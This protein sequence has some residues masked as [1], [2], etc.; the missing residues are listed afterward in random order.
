MRI[1]LPTFAI[2][3]A[4]FFLAVASAQPLTCTPESLDVVCAERGAVR[5]VTEGRTFA[6]KGIPY[7]Q[8][9]VGPLRWKPPVPPSRWDDVRDGNPSLNPVTVHPKNSSWLY[10]QCVKSG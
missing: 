1:R 7:A 3:A 2:L 8:A 6:F 5:G 9:P 4:S 10:V